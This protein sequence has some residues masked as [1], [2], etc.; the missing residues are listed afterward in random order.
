MKVHIKRSHYH[1]S[2]VAPPSKSFCHRYLVA[3]ALSGGSKISHIGDS[4]DISATLDCL[5]AFGSI[6]ERNK[7]TVTFGT[8]LYGNPDFPCGESG[9]TLRFFVPLALTKYPTA[10]FTGSPRLLK[11]GI[12][13]YQRALKTVS[14][15]IK[16]DEIVTRG[17]LLPGHYKMAGNESSQ[18]ISGMLL[19]FPLLPGDSTLEVVGPLGSEPYVRMT[20]QAMEAFGIKVTRKGSTFVVPGNQSYRGV[21]ASVEGDFSNSSFLEALGFLG[22]EVQVNGLREFSSQGDRAYR[23]F[24]PMLHKETSA[25]DLTNC[26]DLGPI[27]FVFACLNHG[28]V[29]VGTKRLRTKE[30]DRGELM[31]KELKKAGVTVS[32][33]PNYIGIGRY[34]PNGPLAFDAHHDHRIAMALSLFSTVSD[35]TIEGAE[36]VKKSFPEYWEILKKLGADLTYE[37]E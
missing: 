17:M 28:G 35:V 36:C 19:A 9:T 14:F 37:G 13:E 20:Q 18:Y 23:D 32:F 6:F 8:V 1:G 10:R 11:R 12:S 27:L 15:D 2:I 21:S 22:G 3:G 33:G 26:I 7:D 31:A 4:E 5:S 30:S 24:F 29:F 25:I 16:K 34:Q